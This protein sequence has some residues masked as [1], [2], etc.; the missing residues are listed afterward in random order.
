M[1][2]LSCVAVGLA[3]TAVAVADASAPPRAQRSS[4]K[5]PAAVVVKT[6]GNELTFVP[7]TVVIKQGETVEWQNLS[8]QLH[9]VTADALKATS[10]ADVVLPKGAAPFDSGYMKP[11]QNYTH[12]FTVRGTYRYVCTLHE[13]QGMKGEIVVK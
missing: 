1:T 10:K 5:R 4:A 9:T 3:L 2:K 13:V 12:R 7:A 6:I 8:T 11:G